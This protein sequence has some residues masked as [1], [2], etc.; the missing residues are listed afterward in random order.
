[1]SKNYLSIPNSELA[2]LIA[3]LPAP[4]Q[5]G[6]Q[7]DITALRAH[8]KNTFTN[9]ARK[10]LGPLLPPEDVYHVEEYTIPRDGGEIA[11]RTYRPAAEED[12]TFPAMLA[13]HGGGFM[14]GD[15]DMEDYYLRIICAD[16]Q[17]SIVNVDYRLAPENPYPAGLNDAYDA[18]KWMTQN[19]A[20]LHADLRKGFI[21][22][23]KSSGGN[24]A[25]VIAHRAKED[26]AFAGTPLTGQILQMPALCHP[27]VVPETLKDKLRSMEE[28]KD[29][30]ILS[31]EQM[32]N[33]YRILKAD[34][35][36]P[37]ISPLLYQSL[38]NLAPA[39]I[40]VCGLDPCRDEA[41]VYEELLRENGVLTRLDRYPGAP[42]GF[43]A[44]FGHTAYAQKWDRDYR[45][46]LRW[47][48]SLT[49]A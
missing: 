24:M 38:A 15:L 18:L 28:C 37:E 30:P 8:L 21:V 43:S 44:I 34:P 23:G 45:G 46:G 22:S 25:A 29:A 26:P 41:L 16:V 13:V 39:Y 10:N 17:I 7:V 27:D 35:S 32:L 4:P 6:G 33:S 31:R 19:E 40:Q 2:P 42:H 9:V 5:P 20:R 12:R 49:M 1:M 3:A 36:N 14:H 48:L 47:L 11:I